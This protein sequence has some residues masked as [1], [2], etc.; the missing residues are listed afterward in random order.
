[1]LEIAAD[2]PDE[3]LR[4]SKGGAALAPWKEAAL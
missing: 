1:L 2:K 3:L 4:V